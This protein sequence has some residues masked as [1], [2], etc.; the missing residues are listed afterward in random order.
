MGVIGMVCKNEKVDNNFSISVQK[1][2]EKILLIVYSDDIKNKGIKFVLG[3]SFDENM[4]QI[5]KKDG[6]E[7]AHVSLYYTDDKD[8]DGE[9]VVDITGLIRT[10]LKNFATQ[11]EKLDTNIFKK[12]Q[13][14]YL[15]P[16]AVWCFWYQTLKPGLTDTVPDVYEYT[17]PY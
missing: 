4:F 11:E 3:H 16:G 12:Y 5:R 13:E 1:Q 10:Y 15:E 17:I 6:K 7:V 14:K 8:C 9:C 2:S